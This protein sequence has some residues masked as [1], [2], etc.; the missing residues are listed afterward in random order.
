MIKKINDEALK[1][2][3]INKDVL[4]ALSIVLNDIKIQNGIEQALHLGLISK[5]GDV[6]RSGYFISEDGIELIQQYNALCKITKNA[7][8]RAL[9]LA[10]K[11]KEIY[12]KGKK[13]GTNY[14][15]A[16][17]ASLIAKRLKTFFDKYGEDFSDEQI[18][19]ATKKYIESFNG[20]NSGMRLLKYFI[21][22]D[23]VGA[24]GDVESSS[25]LLTAME[26]YS[27]TE[28]TQYWNA[29]VR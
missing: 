12:P 20:D 24:G 27:E 2:L 5:Y 4:F 19:N 26:N 17:G 21:W 16:E 13:P 28:Q 29:D 10:R 3:N 6:N 8:E 18:I 25:D 11:L 14:Y 15:W 9:P 7:S 23:S 1:N 22:K